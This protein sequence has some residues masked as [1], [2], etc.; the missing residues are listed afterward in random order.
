MNKKLRY[1]KINNSNDAI[2]IDLHNGYTVVAITGE[3]RETNSFISTLYLKENSIETLRLIGVADKLVFEK[4]KDNKNIYILN[5]VS[6]LFKNGDLQYYI[7]QYE[8][9][10]NLISGGIRI[11]ERGEK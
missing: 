4:T 9:E 11:L 7:D 10:E 5:T 2:S 3:N 6:N 8:L 1:E